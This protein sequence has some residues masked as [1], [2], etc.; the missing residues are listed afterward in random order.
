MKRRRRG[1]GS[2]AAAHAVVA[3][4]QGHFA[5]T[6]ANEALAYAKAKRCGVAFEGLARAIFH[7]GMEKAQ[8]NETTSKHAESTDAV[9]RAESGFK[10][11]CVR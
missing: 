4:A 9:A 1:L 10:R 3:D 7:H 6:K 5:I 2:S 8:R 11:Y